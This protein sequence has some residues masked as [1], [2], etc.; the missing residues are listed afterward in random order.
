MSH[1]V[2]HKIEKTD[3]K[4]LMFA[5]RLRSTTVGTKNIASKLL[6]GLPITERLEKTLR[7]KLTKASRIKMESHKVIFLAQFGLNT[8]RKLPSF[9]ITGRTKE[10]EAQK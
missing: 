8:T 4:F 2:K 7:T 9:A 3:A 5:L 10:I 1:E 6:E